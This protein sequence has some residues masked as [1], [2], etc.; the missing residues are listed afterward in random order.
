MGQ[1]RCEGIACGDNDPTPGGSG[2]HR[3]DGVCDKNGCDFQPFRLGKEDFWGA[4][5]DFVLDT[6]KPVRVITQ[7]LTDDNTDSGKL[8]EIRRSYRQGENVVETPSLQIGKRGEFDSL[9]VDYCNAELELFDDGTNFLDKGG[10]DAT[11]LAFEKGMVLALSLWDDHYA[12]MLWLDSTYPADSTDPGTHRGNCATSSGDPKD[13]ESQ[14]PRA[15]VK[16]MNIAYG[17]LGTSDQKDVPIPGPSPPAPPGPGPSPSPGPSPTPSPPYEC[18]ASEACHCS[19]GKNNDGNN[20][21]SSARRASTADECCDFCQKE[22]R[23]VGWTW[24]PQ[25]GNECWLKDVIGDLRD[26]GYVTSGKVTGK[27]PVPSPTPTPPSPSP[28]SDCPGGSLDACL[29]MCPADD[30]DLFEACV[31]SCQRRCSSQLIV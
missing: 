2:G 11:D 4:G 21:E 18:G 1:T 29:D 13:V 23:C 7:F 6:T 12:N 5:S 27:G 25:S 30:A 10:F 22:E 8:V 9:K 15:F 26:D 17:E 19:P 14:H 20:M 28:P 3:F 16:Y 31:K 24:I